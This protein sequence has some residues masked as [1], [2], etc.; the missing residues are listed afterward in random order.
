MKMKILIMIPAYNEELNIERV[1]NNLIENYPQY[2]YVV[3]NDGSKDDTAKICREKGF[4]LIDLPI[5]LGLSGAV[6]A[7]MR[8]AWQN[9]YDAAIQIDGDGQ[10]RP[11]FIEKLAEELGKDNAQIV[12]GSRFVTQKKPHSLRMLGSNVISAFIKLSTG[13]RLN[14]PTSGMRMFNRDIIKEFALNI[15]YGPEP[16]TISYLIKK[17]VRVKE[18]QVQMDERVAGESYLNFTRSMKYMIL[19]SFSILFIQGFRKR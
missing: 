3:I 12:I 8:Y 9:G 16:D 7:G 10:H 4:H 18:V 13:F 17:G 2:D 1:V 15:N 14:D 6:Q 11:E 5:N 19:M